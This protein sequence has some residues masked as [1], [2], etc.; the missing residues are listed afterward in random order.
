MLTG[1]FNIAGPSLAAR[2]NA[3][4]KTTITTSQGTGNYGAAYP[5]Y[6]GTRAGGVTVRFSGRIYALLVRGAQT[7][8]EQI[9]AMERWVNNRT[10]AY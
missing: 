7:S 9:V 8:Y 1:V 5:L 3:V 6:V 10:G 2:V 4:N